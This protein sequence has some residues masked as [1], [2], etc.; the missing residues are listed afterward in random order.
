MFN[1]FLFFS[2]QVIY[3]LG[4]GFGL[5]RVREVSISIVLFYGTGV[6]VIQNRYRIRLLAFCFVSNVAT[7]LI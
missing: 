7:V 6:Q 2:I 4:R 5:A 1:E 3:Y